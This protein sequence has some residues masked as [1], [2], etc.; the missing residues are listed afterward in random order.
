MNLSNLVSGTIGIVHLI[1]AIAALAFGTLV[2]ARRKGTAAH[3]KA[4]YFYAV[5]MLGLN[6]SAFMIYTL[7]DSFGIFHWM[8]VVSILTLAAGLI[9]MFIKKPANYVSM[10]FG[11]MYWSVIG[12]Y[13]AF[14]AETL[15]RIPDVVIES[16]IPNSTFYNMTGVAVAITMG[17]GAY[18]SIKNNDKWLKFDRAAMAAKKQKDL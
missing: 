17:L 13:G 7:F 5:A 4:G 2:L 11:F 16:G 6:I 12:L 8:A 1:F 9:P 3:K 14:T 15:V 10:H 18:Y